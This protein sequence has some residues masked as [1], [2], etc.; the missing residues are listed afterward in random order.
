MS[1]GSVPVFHYLRDIHLKWEFS[2]LHFGLGLFE[3]QGSKIKGQ[4]SVLKEFGYHDLILG[5]VTHIRP[6][7]S[8]AL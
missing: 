7:F 5:A 4:N 8:Y 2:K 6:H 3:V 1:Q